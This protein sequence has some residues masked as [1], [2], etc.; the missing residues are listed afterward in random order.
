MAAFSRRGTTILHTTVTHIISTYNNN[1]NSIAS[2]AQNIYL[3]IK[4][5]FG[6]EY[7]LHQAKLMYNIIEIIL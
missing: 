7:L 5:F 4:L 2:A 6:L 1:N 3:F